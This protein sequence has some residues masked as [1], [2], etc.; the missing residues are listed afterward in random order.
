MPSG[1]QQAGQ[2]NAKLTKASHDHVVELFDSEH[3]KQLV[4]NFASV[5]TAG[6]EPKSTRLTVHSIALF[7]KL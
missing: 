4:V 5:S 6:P 3:L 7:G 2:S 1:L